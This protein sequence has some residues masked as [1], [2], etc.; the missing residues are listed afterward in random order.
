MNMKL[1]YKAEILLFHYYI[2]L[3][4][5]LGGSYMT[6]TLSDVIVTCQ[7][8]PYTCYC[9][10]LYG[11]HYKSQSCMTHSMSHSSLFY[12]YLWLTLW[13]ILSCV[14]ERWLF[15]PNALPS[16]LY[17]RVQTSVSRVQSSAVRFQFRI[18]T[19]TITSEALAAASLYFSP[20]LLYI[21]LMHNKSLF[22]LPSGTR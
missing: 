2:L 10:H 5:M 21:F 7:L 12:L 8:F 18:K 3:T 15:K 14:P 1:P 19:T 20:N 6:F 9:S 11:S 4:L 17:F 16:L 13:V 22:L